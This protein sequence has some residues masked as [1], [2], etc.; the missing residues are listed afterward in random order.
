MPDASPHVA[1]VNALLTAALPA[2][3]VV[4]DGEVPGTP[5][6]TYAVIYAPPGDRS[7]TTLQGTSDQIE[8]T[9][10]VTCVGTTALQA[11]D[12]ADLVCA[13]LIDQRPTVA[14]RTCWRITQIPGT[15]PIQRDDQTR[16][17]NIDRPRFSAFPRFR[18]ASTP[19]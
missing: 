1:A 5:G 7:P 13:A 10:Q 6:Q 14:G 3:I 18:I 8:L 11:L 19:A 9:I 15:P 12:V 4:Y 17:P 16:D 2:G